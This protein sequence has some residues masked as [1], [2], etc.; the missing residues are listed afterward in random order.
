MTDY[1]P[2]IASAVQ[3]LAKNTGEARRALYERARSALVAQLKAVEP[4]LS[5]SDITK[6][7]LALEEAIRKVESGAARAALAEPRTTSGL[8]SRLRSLP[9]MEPRAVS[10]RQREDEARRQRQAE[11]QR[12]REVEALLQ[13]EEAR[14][15]RN[16]EARRQRYEAERHEEEFRRQL[17]VEAEK[18]E[19][20]LKQEFE[21]ALKKREEEALRPRIIRAKLAQVASPAPS[22]TKDGRLDAGPNVPYDV[23]VSDSELAANE[24][25]TLPLRQRAIIKSILSGLP[26]NAPKQLKTSLESYD[27]E[28]RVRGVQPILDLLKDLAA[29]IQADTGASNATSEWLDEGIR[30]AFARFTKNHNLFLKYF[31]LDPE[32]EEVYRRMVVDENK[33]SGRVLSAPFEAVARETKKAWEANLTTDDFFKVV[34]KVTEIVTLTSTMPTSSDV[35]VQETVEGAP[36]TVKKRALLSGFGFLERVYNLMGS[37]VTLIG[38]EQGRTLL[39]VIREAL[40]AL[41]RLIE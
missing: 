20:V 14:R 4:A 7:R 34:Q 35:R 15:Q 38:T 33:A 41:A 10:E 30:E 23:P 21:E 28:L 9:L 22:L 12:Q 39:A 1:F 19:A 29:I 26:G 36:V 5:E 25:T 6:E 8:W 2:L 32:R 37:T 31:P 13:R 17:E 18:R 16:E 11:V 24:L 40:A 3:G 27:D